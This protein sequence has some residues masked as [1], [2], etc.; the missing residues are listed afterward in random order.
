[1]PEE[2][3]DPHG[4][5]EARRLLDT[6]YAWLERELAGRTWAAGEDFSLADCAAAPSLH[7]ADRV[8][9]LGGRFPVVAGYL[10]RLTAR[11]SFARVLKEAEP[12]AHLFPA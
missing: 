8:H 1:M 6:S 11:P 10:A 7:Y 3:R 9:P 5:E 4:L 2:W 12:Y